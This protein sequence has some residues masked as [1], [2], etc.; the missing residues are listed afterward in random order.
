RR[1]ADTS[2]LLHQLKG[3]LDW[4]V[5]KCLE[6]DRQR[7]YETANGLAADLKRHLNNEPVLARPPSQLYRFQKMARRN[8]AATVGVASVALALLLGLGLS[9]AALVRERAARQREQVAQQ[10]ERT[11]SV[12]ADT[13]TTFIDALL[14]DTL[15]V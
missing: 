11:Q 4:I 2:K 9:T 12:R 6:K 15:P 7:R 13:V 10:R 8:K 3:D 1:S 5:M 14:S